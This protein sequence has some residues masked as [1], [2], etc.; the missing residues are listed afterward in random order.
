MPITLFEHRASPSVP[1]YGTFPWPFEKPGSGDEGG[2]CSSLEAIGLAIDAGCRHLDTAFAY[3][4]QDEVGAAMLRSGLPRRAFF[5]TSKLHVN[6]NSYQEARQKI[7]EAVRVIHGEGFAADDRYLD[8]FLIH[9]P[10]AGDLV[11]TWRSLLE[12]RDKGSVKHIGVSNFEV[13]HLKKIKEIN[14][15]YPEIN[16]I[17]FHPWIVEEQVDTLRFCRDAG[18]AVEGYSPLAQGLRSSDVLDRIAARH[19]TSPA[20]IL[21]KWGMQHRVLPIIGSR[22]RAHLQSNFEAFE[23]HLSKDE[24]SEI[25]ALGKQRPLRVAEQWN[26]NSKTASF[27]KARSLQDRYSELIRKS[28]LKAT[29][30]LQGIRLSLG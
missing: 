29:R 6:N 28:K 30:V 1:G 2:Q 10:G 24:M 17:E 23:F 27:G 22:N 3:G 11:G 13:W 26:W 9:Y 14:G 5:V 7:V 20:R 16:Q 12:A 21:L 8:A 25:D 18:I 15:E 19:E 4:N